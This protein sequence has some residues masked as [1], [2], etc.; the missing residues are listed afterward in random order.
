MELKVG[1]MIYSKYRGYPGRKHEITRITPKRAYSGP[2][3]FKKEYSESGRLQQIGEGRTIFS[4]LTYYIE[5][6]ALKAEYEG[7]QLIEK[8]KAINWTKIPEEKRRAVA[9]IVFIEGSMVAFV[10]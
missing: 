5:T 9:E 1:D 10:F 8:L 3:V 4:M 2:L 6:P 7:W